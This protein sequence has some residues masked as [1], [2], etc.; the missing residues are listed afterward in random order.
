MTPFLK[1]VAAHYHTE[2]QLDRRC[3]IFPNKRALAFFRKYLGDE[4]MAAGVPVIAPQMLTMNDFFYRLSGKAPTDKVHLLIK[5]HECYSRLNPKAE[6]LDDFIFWGDVLLSD[7]D[8]VDKYLVDPSG[9]FTNV[10]QFKGM[11]DDLSYLTDVQEKAVERFLSHFQKEGRIKTEFRKIWDILLPLYNDF[12]SRLEEDGLSYEGQVYRGI[13]SRLADETAVDV[14]SG[15]FPDTDKFI[16][17]GLNALNECEKALMR[18]AANAGI[19]EFCWDYSGDM[20]SDSHNKSSL[21]LSSFV[22]EF[23]QAFRLRE[24]NSIPRFRAISVPSAIGQAKQLPA[25][26]RETGQ[27]PGIETAIILP[28]E[29]MLVPV[30]NSIPAEIKALNVTMGYSM[31]GS[32]L[33]SLMNDIASMQLHIREKDGKLFFYHKQVRAIFSNSLIK[34]VL[35]DEEKEKVSAIRREVKYYIPSADLSG[36]MLF[37]LIF[38]KAGDDIHAI[39]DYQQDIITHIAT[40]IRGNEKMA[41]ELDFAKDLYQAIGRLKA[42]DLP[43][44]PATYFRLLGQLV[45]GSAVPFK[46]EPLKG[47]QI[48]GPLETRAL[49]FENVIILNCN[50]GVFPRHTVSSSFIPPELRKAFGLPTYEFQDAVWAYYFYRLVHRARSVTM[51]YD[52][53]SEGTKSGEESRYVKQLE[54]HFGMPVERYTAK[55]PIRK[56]AVADGIAK[57]RE[58]LDIL[59]GK[60]LSASALQNYLSCKAK[61]HYHSVCGLKEEEEVSESLDAGMLGN[62]F[63]KTMQEIYSHGSSIT[64]AWLKQQIGAPE[65]IRDCVRKHIMDELHT[66]EVTGRNIIFE[67]MV[68]RYVLQVLKRDLELLGRYGV[69]SFHILGLERRCTKRIGGFDFVGYIDRMDSFSPGEVRIVDYKTGKVTDEDFIITE[70]NAGDVVA[71]LFGDRN[72][73]RP[74]IA[75]QL[76]LYDVFA[77]DI[78]SVAGK[79]LV[80]SIYQTSRLFVKEVEEVALNDRFC[81][82]ME[83]SLGRLLDEIDDLSVPWT[84]TADTKVCEYCDFKNICGR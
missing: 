35:S 63:H 80:N 20:I 81:S 62:V 32:A 26:L 75:L 31:S 22:K 66:F 79:R 21:F 73:K 34:T 55:S 10:S 48:M 17:V 6:A 38:R 15:S 28:D 27:V 59:H 83:E 39:E 42:Y 19:A 37:N 77:R 5:L 51:L 71:A 11:K 8:D 41:L 29:T 82:L 44:K 13:A 18:K 54:L 25:L 9:V 36:T 7:F 45:S 72:D 76:Y 47:L 40:L 56:G 23:P 74:K 64:A 61:F 67:D 14:L 70:D 58:H 69:P 78:K 2:G 24:E 50:E 53:R 68:C 16:F 4:V 60:A 30:L 84:R 43:V 46:G 65:R 1:Q 12:R 49:D 3:F 33:W 52:S 57:T